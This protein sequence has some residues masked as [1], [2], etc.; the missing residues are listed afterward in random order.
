VSLPIALLLLSVAQ[1][2]P[3][4]LASRGRLGAGLGL[5]EAR[6]RVRAGQYR[7]GL[8]AAEAHLEREPDHLRARALRVEALGGLRR[9]AAAAPELA[10][11]RPTPAWTARLA[12]LEGECALERGD[13]SAAEVAFTEAL[14][15][16]PDAIG[17]L[18]GRARVLALLQDPARGEAMAALRAHEDAGV[19]DLVIEAQ[20]SVELGLEELDAALA[21]LLREAEGS[22]TLPDPPERAGR[23]R[24]PVARPRGPPS[25]R[26]ASGRRRRC[27]PAVC[28]PR[29]SGRRPCGASGSPRARC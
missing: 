27:C 19:R 1:D 29:C 16:H 7:L 17:A 4:G 24:H 13:L 3:T 22:P 28:R 25:R 9:C 8:A 11:L 15:M 14:H 6:R 21:A 5:K 10:A 26:R 23:R 18:H 20:V 2:R 12:V